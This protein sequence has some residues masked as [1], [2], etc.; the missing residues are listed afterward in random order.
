MKKMLKFIKKLFIVSGIGLG[1]F[2]IFNVGLYIY[3][4]V[5]AAPVI[6]Q[7][8]SY[9]LYDSNNNLLFNDS[10][11]WIDIDEINDY[12]IMATIDT[13][14]KYFYYHLG[15]DYLRILKAALVN[16]RTGS[17][18]EGAS[19]ITQQYA[20]NLF[21]NYDKTWSRKID[22][23]ILASELETHYSKDEIL[24]GY[25]NT[26]NYGGVYGIENASYHYFGHSSSSLTLAEASMLAGIPQSPSNYSPFIN[27]E[28]AKK[29]Q[30]VVL[31]SMVK[32]G[33]ITKEEA[34]EA[35][36][37][38][39]DYNNDEETK[40]YDNL[41]YFRD[42][43]IDEL[44]DIDSIPN[45]LIE[46][47][48]IKIYTTLDSDAQR[49]LEEA[50]ANNMMDANADLQ[51]AGI[52]IDPN[53]G[54]VLALMGGVDY[55]S[56]VFNRATDAVRQV[57]STMKPYL[58]YT[59]LENGFTSS[60]SF[61]SEKTTFSFSNG[62]TY[63]PKN[64]NDTYANKAISMGTAISY[65]DN[66]YAVK[67]N[68]FLGEEML[69][70]TA[71]KLG[72]TSELS[73]IP[74]LALGTEE[75]SLIDMVTAYSDFASMGYKNN[76]HFIVKIED[77]D[78]NVLYNYDDYREQI[79]N[80]DLCYIL[81]EMLTYTYDTSFID[82]NYPT[83]ISLLPKI[84]NKYA[85]KTGTTN[86]DLWI[87]GYNSKAVLGIWTGYDDNRVLEKNDSGYHKNIWI[88]TMENYLDNNN[89]NN[90]WYDKPDDVVGV[91]VNPITG[92]MAKEGDKNTKIFYFVKGTE[93]VDNNS[94][95]LEA[96][97]KEKEEEKIG[98]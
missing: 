21:L 91:L 76:S 95:D 65:S 96:V 27:E 58:Y 25:L 17:L 1:L 22:E 77:K 32:N 35:Y 68:L 75:I 24:E 29:R 67:T 52:M 43:V 40:Y 9:Y 26:I 94:N 2:G 5:T 36:D 39:L 10:N 53:T 57:G 78:G 51:V 44:Y 89:N 45:S 88:D 46:T 79:L 83:V 64:Y 85:I 55:N 63:T 14:D 41:L 54:G 33:D 42:A 80:E 47:G 3:C 19:T 13:E 30:L 66:I 97:W 59:A 69:V 82:Y 87:I 92:E 49:Y 62:T 4:L 48:G 90:I 6:N 12:L 8:Q 71:K 7:S 31:N 84:S 18:S 34:K 73:A 81:S 37:V 72:I 74:S 28:L 93:P 15:F 86:T 23:A 98:Y 56:S 20:R 16:I 70:S 38:N 50:V 11:Q 61:I 60:S